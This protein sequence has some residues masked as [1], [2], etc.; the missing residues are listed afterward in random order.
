MQK[1]IM[2][3][4][5]FTVITHHQKDNIIND[6]SYLRRCFSVGTPYSNFVNHLPVLV[7][8]HSVIYVVLYSP[9]RPSSFLSE[10]LGTRLAMLYLQHSFEVL[11]SRSALLSW[12]PPLL[13]R[14]NRIIICYVVRVVVV[15][16]GADF[17]CSSYAS[18]GVRIDT[19]EPNA[20]YDFSVAAM[21]SIDRGPFTSII[22]ITTPQEGNIYVASFQTFPPKILW[23]HMQA[24]R[25]QEDCTCQTS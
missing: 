3:A 14:Q 7:L 11:S 6:H 4:V 17:K 16:S 8:A 13:K 21:T 20:M 12:I 22:N 15:Q 9:A 24:Y 18:T 25:K 10:G 23:L 5:A 1:I 2:S 19:L